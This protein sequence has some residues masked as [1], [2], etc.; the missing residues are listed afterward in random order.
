MAPAAAAKADTYAG[1]IMIAHLSIDGAT[2]DPE[3]FAS[4][5][6]REVGRAQERV[7]L[8]DRHVG[9]ARRAI[10][11]EIAVGLDLGLRIADSGRRHGR[12]IGR[13]RGRAGSQTC[14]RG[15]E[16][17]RSDHERFLVRNPSTSL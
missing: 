11:D 4:V 12:R 8:K 17:E 5:L 6:K 10:S 13:W 9:A 16:E 14:R 2:I 1:P 7:V 15:N 3:P